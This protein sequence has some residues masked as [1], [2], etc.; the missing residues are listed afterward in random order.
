M[1]VQWSKPNTSTTI[2]GYDLQVKSNNSR[3]G[4]WKSAWSGSGFPDILTYQLTQDVLAGVSYRF[5]VR[6]EYQNGWTAF[7]AESE[8]VFACDAPTSLEKPT[9]TGLTRNSFSLSWLPPANLGSCQLQGFSLMMNNGEGSDTFTEI[10]SEQIR[11]KPFLASHTSFTATTEGNTYIIYLVANNVAGSVKSESI[12]FVLA[13]EPASTADGPVLLAP[14]SEKFQIQVPKVT[15]NGGSPVLEYSLEM[16]DGEG[17]QFIE[18]YRGLKLTQSTTQGLKRGSLYR[19]RSRARNVN[20]WSQYSPTTYMLAAETPSRPGQLEFVSAS[21]AHISISV[22]RVLD[23]GGS[24]VTEYELFID[25]GNEGEM[26]KIA[27]Y[28]QM[29][30]YTI[31]ADALSLVSGRIYR[32]AYSAKNVVGSSEMSEVISVALVSLPE[33]PSKPVKVGGD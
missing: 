22:P 11:N 25:D 15:D 14:S 9:I 12:G 21:P 8:L 27:L 33:A 6:A 3:D 32:L 5:R 17:G 19:A 18:I 13:S 16:D 26:T 2:T 28:D 20:G 29:P 7:S 10:D 24:P 4:I 23:H 30:M 1:A 31:E